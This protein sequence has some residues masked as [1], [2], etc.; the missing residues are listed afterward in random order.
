MKY[1][2]FIMYLIFG[3]F[4]IYAF[5]ER[6]NCYSFLFGIIA[7]IITYIIVKPP[8]IIKLSKLIII[9]ILEIPK[10]IYQAVILS[11]FKSVEGIHTKKIK[12][13]EFDELYNMLKVTLTPFEI[14]VY[15]VN[16]D[17][18]IHTYKPKRKEKK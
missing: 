1:L 6:F 17:M 5:S 15:T 8:D 11:F 10:V 13:E 7:T 2:N 18:I 3:V 12:D 4:I 14:S 9:L 16:N